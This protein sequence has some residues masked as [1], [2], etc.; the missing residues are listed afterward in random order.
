MSV[1][2]TFVIY[3]PFCASSG[4]NV[5]RRG[6]K[7]KE[8]ADKRLSTLLKSDADAYAGCFVVANEDL[9]AYGE[10]PTMTKATP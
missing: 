7:S 10:K 2:Q 4:R 5:V 8:A 1:A 6:F 9:P 3:D